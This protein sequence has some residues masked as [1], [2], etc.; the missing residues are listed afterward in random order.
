MGKFRR[1]W[2][3]FNASMTVL[4]SNKELILFP[5]VIAAL[6]V[7]IV[8]F[9]LAPVALLPTGHSVMQL[10]HWQTVGR[11][12]F[13][14]TAAGE[15]GKTSVTFTPA[16][17][18]YLVFLYL[19]TM[20]AATF[21]N[22]AFYNEILAALTEQ[23]VSIVRGLKFAATRL[24]AIVMWSLL[25]GI[26]GL[27]IKALEQRLGLIGRIVVRLIGVAWSIASVFAIPIIVQDEEATNP[28]E[29]LKKS[30]SIL[31]KTWGEAL[32]GYVGMSFA[33][34]LIVL[35]SVVFLVIALMVSV[36]INN[37]WIMGAAGLIWLVA[38]IS[39]S[40]LL[41][42]AG[43]VYKGALYLYASNGMVAQPYSQDM[44]ATAW[45]FKKQK[46]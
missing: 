31:R 33:S 43:Q 24:K 17:V 11:T 44:F 21:L 39:F 10:E 32:I 18:A 23:P 1:S 46:S 6:M 26:V 8:L 28:L 4:F 45:K 36:S 19:A 35:G 7:V 12:F 3:L 25:A 27:I 34:G 15:D 14:E 38:I 41:S 29:T 37:F 20:F 2:M 40:Y 22:V 16:A 30:A 13:Q 42:L 9:F 5:I